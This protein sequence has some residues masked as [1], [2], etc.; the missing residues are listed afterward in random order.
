MPYLFKNK[1]STYIRNNVSINNDNKSHFKTYNLSLYYLLSSLFLCR[2]THVM[3]NI[4]L[5]YNS[6]EVL[7]TSVVPKA[8]TILF[9]FS[10]T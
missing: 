8:V 1:I 4:E 6:L 10:F 7:K 5:Y 3:K 2:I 9:F